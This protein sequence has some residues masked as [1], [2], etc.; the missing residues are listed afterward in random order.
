MARWWFVSLTP[1][2]LYSAS[3]FNHPS[4]QTPILAPL[5]INL[6]FHDFQALQT[7]QSQQV[8]N[9][10]NWS[11]FLFAIGSTGCDHICSWKILKICENFKSFTCKKIESLFFPMKNLASITYYLKYILNTFFSKN[12]H[13]TSWNSIH[14]PSRRKQ[15]KSLNLKYVDT[16]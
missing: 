11:T 4:P 13:L 6:L 12:Y 15:S 7:T 10:N 3:R 16:Y 8:L 1:P 5:L 9:L 14:I 2:L